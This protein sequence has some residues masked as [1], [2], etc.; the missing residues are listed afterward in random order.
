[1]TQS[2]SRSTSPANWQPGT[3]ERD[4]LWI[5][6]RLRDFIDNI[7]NT[8]PARL[9]LTRLRRRDPGLHRPAVAARGLRNGTAHTPA[10]G[11]LHG[12]LRRLRHGPDGGL[13]GRALVLL[14]P[15][16]H[17]GGYLRGRPGYF[18]ARVAAGAHGQQE[19]R[20]PRQTDRPGGHERR[21][22]PRRG[23]H[24]SADRDRNLRGD[25]GGPGAGSDPPL[26][27]PR[28][29][30]PAGR[31]ARRLLRNF[32]LQQRRFHTAFR[33]DRPV[34]DRSVDPRT[35]HAGRVPGQPGL[36]SGD[37]ASAERA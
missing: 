25:R 34:R 11:P 20:R 6:T 24:A 8:S 15:A 37:G 1:M 29:E 2:Q 36:P 7:A 19:T 18:D 4:G 32:V 14:R 17:P 10:P 28:R 33:R 22:P 3:P 5:F 23:R 30:F 27:D 12:G 21:W 31:V 35:A 16:R 9:A 13:H 26:P